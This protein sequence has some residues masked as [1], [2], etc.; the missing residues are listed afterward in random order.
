MKQKGFIRQINYDPISYKIFPRG[1]QWAM[2][3]KNLFDQMN[4]E[5]LSDDAKNMLLKAAQ[6]DGVIIKAHSMGERRIQVNGENI[7]SSQDPRTVAKWE[8]ALEELEE[9]GFIKDKGYKGEV[10]GVTNKGYK[11][12]DRIKNSEDK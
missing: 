7:I 9:N 4:A 5:G 3:N 8:G 1:Y 10:F 11:Y 2:Q 12:A 6:S